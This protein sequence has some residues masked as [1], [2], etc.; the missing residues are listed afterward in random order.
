M[1]GNDEAYLAAEK[2]TLRLKGFTVYVA[3]NKQILK[4]LIEEIKPDLLFL[5]FQRPG[6]SDIALYHSVLDDVKIAGLPVVFT[7][8]EDDVYLVNR[9]RT[10]SREKRNITAHNVIKAIKLAFTNT[11]MVI[12]HLPF[13]TKNKGG[14]SFYA[15]A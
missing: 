3:T 13:N 2:E 4:D 8:S 7:L 11:K 14:G 10:V 6:D 5:N 15:S 12:P 1:A 9:K